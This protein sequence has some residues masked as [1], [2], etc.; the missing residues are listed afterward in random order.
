[1]SW[2]CEADVKKKWIVSWDQVSEESWLDGARQA[3]AQHRQVFTEWHRGITEHGQGFST[4]SR[5]GDHASMGRGPE[6]PFVPELMQVGNAPVEGH[7]GRI[8]YTQPFGA[9]NP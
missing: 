2:R 8:D 3:W 5:P 1:M 7:P 4:V 6:H 9:E